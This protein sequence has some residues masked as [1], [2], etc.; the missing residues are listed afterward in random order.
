MKKLD[1]IIDERLNNYLKLFDNLLRLKTVAAAPV[2]EIEEAAQYLKNIFEE[3]GYSVD[4]WAVDGNP[5][6]H[7]RIGDGGKTFVIY[8]HY[9][10]QPAEPFELWDYPPFQLS[11]VNNHLYGRG[12]ADNKGNIVARIM[13]TDLFIEEYGDNYS[14][15]W[16]IEGEEEIG[17]PTLDKV[18]SQY[19]NEI[20]GD[21]GLWETGYVRPDNRLGFPLGYKG[22]IYIEIKLKR[23]KTDVHSGYA[24]IIPNPALEIVELISK[25]KRSDGEILFKDIYRDI[26]EEYLETAKEM[27]E[28][29]PYESMGDLLNLLGIDSFVGGL[30]PKEAFLKIVTEPSLNIA[31]LYSGYTGEGSKTIVPSEAGVKIDIRPLPGQNPNKILKIFTDYLTENGFKDID[32]EI[33]SMYPS[34]YTKPNE[35]IIKYAMRA[36]KDVY[37]SE[38]VVSPLSGGS[39]PI[40]IFTDK[41]RI[42]LAGS[43]VGYYASRAH[44]PN[45]NIRLEDFKRG[46]KHVYNLLK[47]YFQ[48]D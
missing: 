21:A 44:A 15:E 30:T 7:A 47:L 26:D 22:M 35:P 36:A 42:P 32:I 39:G 17:S 40:Y 8:N 14:I 28:E 38:A 3:R 19:R 20:Y 24:P 46:V 1:S 18:L 33:H 25:L 29:F 6:I 23:L 10:V 2:N 9:D 13:A 37:G 41:L 27:A 12:V 43:G 34:G 4:I 45:E 11:I 5:V 31:G 48:V 16:I